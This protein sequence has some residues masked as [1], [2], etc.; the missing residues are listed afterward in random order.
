MAE[1]KGLLVEIGADTSKMNKALNR[2]NAPLKKIQSE[3][4]FIDKAL[5][6]NPK[7]VDLLR[8]K[9]KLMQQAIKESQSNTA[10][11]KAELARLRANNAPEEQIRR[12]ER[13]IIMAEAE[14]KKLRKEFAL[15]QA[16]QSTLGKLGTALSGLGSKLTSVGN[17]MRT[18]SMYTGMATA[19]VV[20]LGYKAVSHADDLNTLSKQSGIATDSLQ[21]FAGASNLVDVS[22]E[23]MAKGQAKVVKAMKSG[24]DIFEKY[25]IEVKKADGTM[26][27]SQ[28]VFYDFMDAMGEIDNKT[29][30]AAAMQEL[31]GAKAYQAL[32][33]LAGNVDIIR[34][35]GDRF[36]EL[37][38]ILDQKTLD[39]MN[40]LNDQ[41]D[42]LRAVGAM[43][44]YKIGGAISKAF[45]GFGGIDQVIA[46]IAD[47]IDKLNPKITRMVIAFG[48]VST[49]VAPLLIFFGAL[50]SSIGVLASNLA[51]V[52]TPLRSVFGMFGTGAGAITRLLGPIGLAISAFTLLWN[53]S[54]EFREA[55]QELVRVLGGSLMQIFNAMKPL[56]PVLAV[57]L[58]QL[59]TIIGT[60]LG[61]AIK[62]VIP[63]ITRLLS[64]FTTV[65]TAIIG[66]VTRLASG[67]SSKFNAIKTKMVTP[68][69]SAKDLIKKAVNKI[70]SFF[71]LKI[72]KIFSGMKLPHFN[73]SGGKA[74]F[75]IGGK[76]SRPSISVKWY[77]TGGIFDGTTVQALGWGE[78]APEA[79]IP[80]SGREMQPFAA[81]IA[82]NFNNIIDYGMLANAIITGLAS[83]SS[84]IVIQI[85]GKTVADTTAPYMN[86]AINQIQARQARQL[87]LVGV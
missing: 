50:S 20:A 77:K 69:N 84:P 87:G 2:L 80:L 28:D 35:Y 71:P 45:E 19:G 5:K 34:E 10:K 15:F 8:Q 40:A 16:S 59:A 66:V 9:M 75:G 3:L 27:D 86:T 23:N 62:A 68:I 11:L 46:N 64:V 82:D 43:A 76:G 13:E 72:G 37:G 65:S 30:R 48:A 1:T 41:I 57:L 53:N 44:F 79:I 25:G 81:A 54:E 78:K 47:Y 7:N 26:R 21:K 51:K 63:V 61:T 73:V 4:K 83:A 55:I 18:F 58:S 32:M 60:V 33:P 31:F 39:R 24:S 17:S 70:K 36:E 74:P 49:I 67:I 56:L 6:L 29:E 38:L 14:T 42:Y 52:L 22:T 12:L 85:D